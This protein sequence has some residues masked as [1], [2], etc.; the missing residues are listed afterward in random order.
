MNDFNAAWKGLAR[1]TTAAFVLACGLC[2][3]ASAEAQGPAK[4]VVLVHGAFADGSSW[5]KVI[6]ILERAGLKVVAVQNP[7]DS[8]END[9]A[10][11]NR[12]IASAEGPVVL[13]GHSYGGVVIT[14]A[15]L[16]DKVKALVYVAAYAPDVGQSLADTAKPYPASPG[17]A[18]FVKDDQGFL[19]ISDDGIFKYFAPDLPRPEQVVVAATQGAFSL[20]AVNAPVTVAAWHKVPSFMVITTNDEIASPQMQRDE[21]KRMNAKSVEVASSHVAMLSHPDVVARLIIDASK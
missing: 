14:Q 2:G 5:S 12:A 1:L 10:F 7:L 13:V 16:A 19:K 18:T 20:K 3:P 21:A 4:T 15:G 11:T 9:V 8:L 6:P 17:Q